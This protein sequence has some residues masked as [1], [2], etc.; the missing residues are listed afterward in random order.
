[1]RDFLDQ[2]GVRAV[3]D[4]LPEPPEAR[5]VTAYEDHGLMG[6]NPDAPRVC[7]TQTLGGKWSKA[8]L[9]VLT[10]AFISAV[11]QGRYKPIEHTWPP[12]QQDVVRKRCKTKLYATQRM[13]ISRPRGPASDKL[14]RMFSRRQEVCICC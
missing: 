12:M 9:E 2:K 4:Y 1:M 3:G 8:V 10:G 14:N 13:C 7:L 11:R 6:P 5:L